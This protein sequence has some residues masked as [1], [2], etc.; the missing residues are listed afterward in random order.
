MKIFY[1]EFIDPDFKEFILEY[2]W[3]EDNGVTM[4][5][6]Q[7]ND[8]YKSLDIRKWIR[9]LHPEWKGKRIIFN[10]CPDTIFNPLMYALLGK[11]PIIDKDE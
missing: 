1:K 6:A 5:T 8:P 10:P 2:A 4:K 7:T 3:K 9:E 11:I